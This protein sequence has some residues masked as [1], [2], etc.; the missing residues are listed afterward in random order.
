[1]LPLYVVWLVGLV[2]SMVHFKKNPKVFLLTLI[3]MAGFLVTS[4]VFTFLNTRMPMIWHARGMSSSQ[5]GTIFAILNIT[6]SLIST[7]LWVLLLVA[8]F[9][10]AGRQEYGAV[11]GSLG[12]ATQKRLSRGGYW[13]R[14]LIAFPIG[15]VCSIMTTSGANPLIIFAAVAGLAV[16]IYMIVQGVR[17]MHDVDKSG[18]FLLVPMYNLVLML[19]DGTPG[20]NRFGEDPRKRGKEPEEKTGG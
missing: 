2:L 18:W 11:A 3:A 17:R 13:I 5:V 12:N 6:H 15:L 7:G 10:L 16:S 4:P 14:W 19:T 20:S 9:G 8:I 1:M